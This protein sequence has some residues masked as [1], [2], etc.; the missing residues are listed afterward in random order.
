MGMVA[1]YTP[2]LPETYEIVYRITII[3]EKEDLDMGFSKEKIKQI[4]W[5]MVLA[6]ALVL[7][8]IYSDKVFAGVGFAFQISR[9]IL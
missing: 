1:G 7:G 4:R 3:C 9:P 5:L 6:A 8:I 2:A